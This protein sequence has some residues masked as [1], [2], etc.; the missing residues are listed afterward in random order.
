MLDEQIRVYAVAK[1]LNEGVVAN[2]A[3]V[4]IDEDTTI[5]V[6]GYKAAIEA[7]EETFKGLLSHSLTHDDEDMKPGKLERKLKKSWKELLESTDDVLVTKKVYREYKNDLG[8]SNYI[9]AKNQYGDNNL[10]MYLQFENLLTYLLFTDY[11]AN[12]YAAHDG[13]YSV[14]E[15]AYGTLEYLFITYTFEAE[16]AE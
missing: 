8:R 6:E 3:T 15:N 5:T 13:E 14:K 4:V 10:R 1:A 7:R 9:Y 11:Q 2:G 16:D 12:D